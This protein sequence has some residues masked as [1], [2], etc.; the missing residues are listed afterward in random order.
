MPDFDPCGCVVDLIRSCYYVNMSMFSNRPDIITR[1]RWFF[2]DDNAVVLPFAT[3]F[4]SGNWASEVRD[5]SGPGEVLPRR[6]AY[7]RGANVPFYFG[8]QPCGTEDQFKD[9]TL[10]PPGPYPRN[11]DGVPLCCLPPPDCHTFYGFNGVVGGAIVFALAGF[12]DDPSQ[13]AVCATSSVWNGPWDDTTFTIG[14]NNGCLWFYS[15]SSDFFFSATLDFMDT[16]NIVLTLLT[17]FGARVAMRYVG[18]V[19]IPP[20]YPVTWPLSV[21]LTDD[22]LGECSG[23]GVAPSVLSLTL[24]A[25]TVSSFNSLFDLSVSLLS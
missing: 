9:G 23:L 19:P 10:F 17:G 20:S 1:V 25:R 13:P 11:I 6:R 21:S 7:N 8:Q 14:T 16:P 5:W 12:T 3:R 22:G 4:A 15:L 18:K 2:A 24:M